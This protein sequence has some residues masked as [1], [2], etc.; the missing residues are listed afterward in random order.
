MTTDK[1]RGI[2]RRQL[3][4]Y[5]G[6]GGAVVSGAALPG[7]TGC[8]AA[9]AAGFNPAIDTWLAGIASSIAATLITDG[10]QK[11][12]SGAFK[13]STTPVQNQVNSATS[14]STGYSAVYDDTWAHPGPPVVLVGIVKKVGIGDP[15][16]DRLVACV[17]GGKQVVE[18]ETWAWQGLYLYID[19]LTY[20]KQG[21]DLTRMQELCILSL[22]PSGVKPNA[23]RSPQG[24]VGWMTYRTRNGT[25]EIAYVKESDGTRSAFVTAEGIPN[26]LGK[27]T[28]TKFSLPSAA[29]PV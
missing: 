24:T 17:D 11:G 4:R 29:A 2:S 6:N 27:P 18:F 20:G 10:V 19:S 23:G 1:R 16:T 13:S 28:E 14:R 7:V 21:A 8:A 9:A 12:L 25:V 15:M 22:I 26:E 3:I 5:A